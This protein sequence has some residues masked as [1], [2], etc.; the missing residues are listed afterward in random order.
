MAWIDS[1]R[2]R[3]RADKVRA[4]GWINLLVTVVV[5]GVHLPDG[6]DALAVGSLWAALVMAV[7]YC[8][9]WVLDRHAERV[10]RR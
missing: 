2:F 5:A 3:R 1:M 4:A 10:V 9:A 7:T 6:L 8:L